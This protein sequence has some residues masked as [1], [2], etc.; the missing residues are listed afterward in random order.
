MRLVVDRRSALDYLY[1]MAPVPGPGLAVAI[2]L[3]RNVISN[4]AFGFGK[5]SMISG[6]L[7]MLS[8]ACGNLFCIGET[9]V[10]AD[11]RR[12]HNATRKLMQR[13]RSGHAYVRARKMSSGEVTH[14]FGE[15]AA[16]L[17]DRQRALTQQATHD[18]LTALPNR[19]EMFQRLANRIRSNSQDRFAVMFIDLDRFKTINDSLGHHHGDMLLR[20]VV[21][22]MQRV[23]PSRHRP[24]SFWR[25]RVFD[26]C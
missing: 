18:A 23:L 21:A 22:R 9:R 3:P 13:R 16:R 14:A 6:L 1:G 7:A 17:N 24:G 11:S 4:E 25:R 15:M 8:R 2:V 20:E 26:D 12:L 19:T 5:M 10:A